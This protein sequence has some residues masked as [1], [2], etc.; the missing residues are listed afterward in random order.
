MP[1]RR[2]A[3]LSV[4]ALSVGALTF[5][6]LAP[7]NAAGGTVSIDKT[8]GYSCDVTLYYSQ[9]STDDGV[10]PLG[11]QPVSVEAQ[12]TV[13]STVQAGTTV[14][15]T[16]TTISL[17]M[18]PTLQFA[19]Y[20]L[21][22]RAVN[23]SSDDA[24]IGFTVAGQQTPVPIDGLSVTGSPVPETGAWTIP[25]SGTAEA[26]PVP[27]AAGGQTATLQMP[28]H[29]TAKADIDVVPEDE[30]MQDGVPVAED[31][32]IHSM[33]A[34]MDCAPNAGVSTELLDTPISVT[35]AASSITAS[36]ATPTYGSTKV[37]YVVA[38]ASAGD[39]HVLEGDTVVGTGTV[40]ADGKGTASL[41]TLGAGD[42]T[43]TVSF[44]GTSAALAST[45]SVDVTVAK[46]ATSISAQ[47]VSGRYGTAAEL[48]YN[49]D[50]PQSGTVTVLEGGKEIAE[51]TFSDGKGTVSL[52]ATLAVGSHT[53][54]VNYAGDANADDASAPVEVTIAKAATKVAA[55]NVT[56]TYGKAPQ[57]SYTVT[58][59]DAGNVQVREG[60]KVLANGSFS[61]GKGS[62][63]LP[64]TLAAG[65]H[66]L[67]VTYA[68]SETLASSSA[69]VTVS[70]AKAGSSITSAKAKPKKIKAKKTKAKVTVQVSSSVAAA[71]TVVVKLKGKTI[72]TATVVNGKAT[73][74]LK[75]FKK[76]GK[77]KLTISYTGSANING[78]TKTIKVKVK[79]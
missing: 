44:L 55:S 4:G 25:I 63:A 68:G 50:G 42:H 67:T 18:S 53:V 17:G 32:Q 13:P 9:G 64:A 58:G 59:I 77:Q 6:A 36:A 45:T 40:D 61:G 11:P 71:G 12:A 30:Q 65:V 10:L 49:V 75:K 3:A 23:G 16:P 41:P 20:S 66:K 57:V 26:I 21:F 51:G 31:E 15:E 60:S 19:T 52:P 5:G 47:D 37:S 54:T 8:F 29:F 39:V 76:A 35:A 28:A 56:A 34:T 78:A 14:P 33:S 2:L 79:K 38:N 62:V 22:G 73:V 74:K 46:A 7:A 27:A 43:L 69:N 72:G 1:K 48:S 24:T 70:V